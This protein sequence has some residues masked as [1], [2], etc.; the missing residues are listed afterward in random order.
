MKESEVGAA[1]LTSPADY[2]PD[3]EDVVRAGIGRLVGD[4]LVDFNGYVREQED[5]GGYFDYKTRFKSQAAIKEI[6]EDVLRGH[7]RAARRNSDVEFHLDEGLSEQP[8]A[9]GT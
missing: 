1:V 7:Q 4:I 8:E 5:D 2:L 6:T 9:L 3:E